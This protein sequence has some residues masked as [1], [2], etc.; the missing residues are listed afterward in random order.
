MTGSPRRLRDDPDFRWETG[1]DLAD[2]GFAVGGYDLPSMRASVLAEVTPPS[3]GA[4]LKPAPR[5][6]GWWAGL[7]A[8]VAVTLLVGGGAYVVSSTSPASG[9]IAGESVDAPPSPEPTDVPAA[10]PTVVSPTEEAA[11][12]VPS[13]P[14]PEEARAEGAPSP[15]LPPT[16]APAPP[17]E[18]AEE[19]PSPEAV[20]AATEPATDGVAE[21]SPPTDAATQ[22]P[23]AAPPS[24]LRAELE[25]YDRGVHA[26]GDG[27][28]PTAR[29]AFER[30]LADWPEGRLRDEA[31]LGLLRTLVQLGDHAA[32][33]AIAVTIQ[34]QPSLAARR[35]E[36]V[37]MRAENLVWL[38]RCDLALE[39]AGTLP[40]RDG[41]DVRRACRRR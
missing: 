38:E 26:L 3:Q 20:D 23:A 32:V 4:P 35:D 9:P 30:Y 18:V 25:A 17:P 8:G 39:L 37:R 21:A 16:E 31:S 6:Q 7:A 10:P 15:A 27:E 33:E 19:P 12:P 41:A 1:C 24:G 11:A 36:V 40:S 5:W 29:A 14:A 34:E 13:M 2:E 28:L 22:T